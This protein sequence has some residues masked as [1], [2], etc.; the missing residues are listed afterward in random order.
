M[1]TYRK[2]KKTAEESSTK[3]GESSCELEEGGGRLHAFR[4]GSKKGE[5]PLL[6]KVEK[7]KGRS[8]SGR[9]KFLG[10]GMEGNL[11]QSLGEESKEV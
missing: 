11:D 2:G 8:S 9:K 4:P 6:L 10:E 7:K 3:K 1:H 5:L